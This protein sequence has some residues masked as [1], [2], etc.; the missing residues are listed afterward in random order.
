MSRLQVDVESVTDKRRRHRRRTQPSPVL[1]A[2]FRLAPSWN[3]LSPPSFTFSELK[4]FGRRVTITK[5]RRMER[6]KA[7]WK[8][9]ERK[10]KIDPRL[11]LLFRCRSGIPFSSDG[12]VIAEVLLVQQRLYT[13]ALKHTTA[14]QGSAKWALGSGRES[15]YE[16]VC[17]RR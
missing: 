13:P 15:Y 14:K 8:A 5:R 7:T 11:L 17:R 6:R 10:C 16:L 3:E 4:A 2:P 9:F 12:S 1:P